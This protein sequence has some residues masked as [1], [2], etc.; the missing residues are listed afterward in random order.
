ML[1]HRDYDEDQADAEAH[2]TAPT[3][4]LQ[5]EG[6]SWVGALCSRHAHEAKGRC[7]AERHAMLCVNLH[8]PAPCAVCNLAFQPREQVA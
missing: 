6:D 3:F 2:N 5:P 7:G 4:P 8:C 1:R